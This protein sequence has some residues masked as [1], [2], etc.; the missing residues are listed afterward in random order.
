MEAKPAVIL[1][2]VQEEPP[3]GETLSH[4]EAED[5]I[6]KFLA[7]G[8]EIECVDKSAT[9]WAAMNL[10]KYNRSSKGGK[11]NKGIKR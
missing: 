7:K 9:N 6:E 2:R 4:E 8:G 1:H 5:H 3:K 10:K 11:K